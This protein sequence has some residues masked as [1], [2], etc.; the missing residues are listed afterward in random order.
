VIGSPQSWHV[1][2]IATNV[3]LRI[4]SALIGSFSMGMAA[5]PMGKFV[6]FCFIRGRQI[7]NL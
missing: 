2:S 5:D 3:F 7:L 6:G 4:F 1:P